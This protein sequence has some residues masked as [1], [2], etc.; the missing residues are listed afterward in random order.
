MSKNGKKMYKRSKNDKKYKK[1]S[2]K[3]K[4]I[5]EDASLYTTRSLLDAS[6]HL[7]KLLYVTTSKNEGNGSEI[8]CKSSYKLIY[9]LY[10]MSRNVRKYKKISKK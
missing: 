6:S 1:M 3:Y 7:Y 8:V 2:K 5:K 4:N 9:Y 10:K